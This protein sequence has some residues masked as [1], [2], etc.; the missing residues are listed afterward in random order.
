M[1]NGS[2]DQH[3]YPKK[4]NAILSWESRFLILKSVAA[5]LNY[6]HCGWEQCIL[7]RDIKP[8]NVMLDSQMNARL[9]DFGLARL[10][11]HGP[12][13]ETAVMSNV[14]NVAGTPGYIAPVSNCFQAFTTKTDVYSFGMMALEVACGRPPHVHVE[15]EESLMKWVWS[16]HKKGQLLEVI[17]DSLQMNSKL[18]TDEV[19][20]LQI[21]QVTRVL[22]LG[23]LCTMPDPSVRPRTERLLQALKGD[24]SV[25]LPASRT[26]SS[27]LPFPLTSSTMYNTSSSDSLL[28][29]DD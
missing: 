22:Q 25:S 20:Q 10:A 12:E 19:L 8:S 17:D 14:T 11:K 3:L 13:D 7:H 21:Q 16:M 27:P 9:G 15:E 5:A 24:W 23:I 18:M 6:L 2:L 4:V 28:V 29:S 26:G 1:A